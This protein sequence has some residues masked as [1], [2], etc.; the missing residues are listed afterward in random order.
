MACGENSSADKETRSLV[1][2]DGHDGI[3]EASEN[4]GSVPLRRFARAPKRVVVPY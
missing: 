1:R 4:I 2:N 3:V